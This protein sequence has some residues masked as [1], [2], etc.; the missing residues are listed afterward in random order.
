MKKYISLLFCLP[1]FS[2]KKENV[3]IENKG[4][5][6]SQNIAK[7]IPQ[8]SEGDLVLGAQLQNPYTVA[9][10]VAA[11]TAIQQ[12]GYTYLLPNQISATHY[13]VKFSPSDSAQYEQLSADSNLKVYDYPLDYEITQA[14]N[15]YHDP[16][17]PASTP[18]YQYAAVKTNYVFPQNITHQVLAEMYI[19]EEDSRIND[20]IPEQETFLNKLLDRAY[21]Q[22]GNFSDT[23]GATSST[24]KVTRAK[25]NPG[26]KIEIFDTRLGRN[27]GL[28]GVE[29]RARRWFTT[30]SATTDFNGNYRMSGRFERDCN[31][32]LWFTTLR[33]SVREHFFGSTTWID[34]PKK[35]GDWNYVIS[36]GYLRF[37]GHIFR[38][39][40]RYHYSFIDGLQRPFRPS[41]N[42]TLFLAKNGTRD[43]SGVNYGIFP[44]LKIARNSSSGEYASD[45]IF[46]TTCHELAHTSHIVKMNAGLIQYL[47]V[48]SQLQES[49]PVAVEWWLTKLEYKTT[50]SVANYGDWN[51]TVTVQ[52]PNN[53]A[54][55]YWSK[56]THS[57]DYTNLYINLYDNVNDFFLFGST[58]DRVQGYTFANIEANILKHVYGISSLSTRLKA[59]KP[60][61]VTDGQIDTLLAAY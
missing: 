56:A 54:Y 26:G 40:F 35:G 43:W 50:R 55:Q 21:V 28:E 46:S 19:P 29:M 58:K 39:A 9:N 37:V 41:G 31:Y 23:L 30:Y 44:I 24:A 14:G 33:F 20:E 1:I 17:L 4:D 53:Q 45:E 12:Q 10:M 7:I 49:W 25:Y 42:R 36:G 60:S 52:H 48:S 11:A 15:R 32:S 6:K 13:Y 5:T 22:T 8:D 3:V 59:F 57:H 61:G 18:T 51:Y 47:Q 27:I 38:G 16:S 34:G 2:C